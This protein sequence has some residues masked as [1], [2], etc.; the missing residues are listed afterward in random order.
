MS[1]GFLGVVGRGA[2][3][4]TCFHSFLFVGGYVITC[5]LVEKPR[6]IGWFAKL[7]ETRGVFHL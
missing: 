4:D 3:R 6:R 5:G 2:L 7:F 1:R